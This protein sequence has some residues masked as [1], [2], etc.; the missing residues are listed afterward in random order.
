MPSY[1]KKANANI[2]LT[3]LQ[4]IPKNTQGMVKD[5]IIYRSDVLGFRQSVDN[6]RIV[7]EIETVYMRKLGRRPP[8]SER[9]AWTNSMRFMESILRNSKVPN[10]CGVLIEYNI[11]S[12]SKRID[13]VVSGHDENKKPNF[14]IVELKQWEKAQATDKEDLVITFIGKG[15]Q[16]VTHPAYQANSY[17]KYLSDMNTAIYD[18]EITPVSCAYLHNYRRSNPEPLLSMQYL[19]IVRESPL[20]FSDQALELQR[21][22]RKYVGRGHGMDIL[23]EIEQGKIVPSKKFIEYISDIFDGNDVYTLLDEQKVAYANIISAATNEK[24]KTTTGKSVVAMNSF[25]TLLKKSH[26]TMFVAPNASFKYAMVSMLSKPKKHSKSRLQAL[27]CGSA[28]FVDSRP[29]EFDT[30]ICDEAHRLKKKGAYMYRGESQIEDIIKASRIN[31][32]FIDDNQ[33]IR[34]DDE[35]TIE[36]ICK[37]AT[38]HRSKVIRIGLKAQFRCSGAEGYLNWVN[39]TL[40]IADTANFDGWD[41]GAFEFRLFDD[42]MEMYRAIMEKDM[43]G[44]KARL[45]AGFAWP[46]TQGTAGNANAEVFDV[47][48]PEYEFFMPWNS[49]NSSSTWAIDD[50]KRSQVGCV[51]TSQGLEFDYVGVIIG[52]DLRYDKNNMR[53]FASYSD[54]YD[55]KGKSGLKNKPDELTALVKNVYRIL[56]SRGMKGCYLYCCDKALSDYFKSRLPSNKNPT[57]D[58]AHIS[59]V[60]VAARGGIVQ[61]TDHFVDDDALITAQKK[62]KPPTNL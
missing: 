52:K 24:E 2:S 28:G 35:G 20:F 34:P 6:N 16:E 38:S 11:P 13:F 27:F 53:L 55:T 14:V 49:R 54:Y 39:H 22:I 23:Y 29:N 31:V 40:Q 12:T 33:R 19:D 1:H 58:A 8:G 18:S 30:L 7:S 41:A 37:T 21:F 45:L 25:V 26:N 42:P 51:H 36:A 57:I 48:I 3:S 59:P 17:K 47:T 44:N 5:M 60:A 46:W 9:S 62:S 61:Y 43:F 15:L 4:S 32:F 10:H 56:L 50:D